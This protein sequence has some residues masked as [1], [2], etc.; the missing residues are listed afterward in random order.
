[1]LAHVVALAIAASRVAF[2]AV[3]HLA[4]RAP[5]DSF[6]LGGKL[7]IASDLLV[8]AIAMAFGGLRL[9]AVLYLTV[10]AA[11]A[12]LPLRREAPMVANLLVVARA[13]AL[14]SGSL[15]TVFGFADPL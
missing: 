6:A 2:L 8:V 7:A 14:G 1:V 10:C 11:F 3:G 9:L 15:P 13:V 4:V 5:I 12:V